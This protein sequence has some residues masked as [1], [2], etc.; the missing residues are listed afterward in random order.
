MQPGY[1]VTYNVYFNYYS[2]DNENISFYF[3]GNNHQRCSVRK[4]AL[5][6]FAKFTG[7]YLCQSLFFNKVAGSAEGCDCPLVENF[8]STFSDFH[9]RKQKYKSEYK[10][11]KA[12]CKPNRKKKHTHTY[13][14]YPF[15]RF[16]FEQKGKGNLLELFF[17]I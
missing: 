17:F 11:Y 16:F 7:K 3:F 12:I 6:N 14:C 10:F 4:G 15:T 9:K 13:I 8:Q 5:R 2:S 1:Y